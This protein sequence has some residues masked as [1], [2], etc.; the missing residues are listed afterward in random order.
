MTGPDVTTMARASL[1]SATLAVCA[2]VASSAL[3]DTRPLEARDLASLSRGETVVREQTLTGDDDRRLVGGLAYA[4]LD[5]QP[6]VV[7]AV[8]TDPSA[9]EQV[10]PRTRSAERV[11][12]SP[13]DQHIAISQGN[14]L[15]ALS[16]VVHVRAYPREQVV[17]FWL[18]ESYPHGIDDAW[19]FVRAEP[20][21]SATGRA[22]SLVSYGVLVELGS[23]IVRALYEER[24][25]AAMLS[26]PSRLRGYLANAMKAPPAP[27]R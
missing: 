17:R 20:W 12:G 26:V 19:G 8:F 22:Q 15:L 7:S 16:Y 25:R 5:A 10:F 2:T 11:S 9:Y 6:E 23:G 13:N 24:L 21:R 3:A 4:V 1:F 27:S 18:D 14:A